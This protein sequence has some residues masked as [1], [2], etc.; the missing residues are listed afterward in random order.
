[1][2]ASERLKQARTAFELAVVALCLWAALYYTPMGALVRAVAS[3][4]TGSKT[5]A[6]PLL[7]YYNGG[8]SSGAS[9]R[10]ELAVTPTDPLT[11]DESLGWGA[12]GA[13]KQASGA[14]QQTVRA[15][16]AELGGNAARLESAPGGP[17]EL[18]AA[19]RKLRARGRRDT[20]AMLQLFAGDEAARFAE[21]RAEGEGRGTDLDDL[22]RQLPPGYEAGV[23]AASL[24]AMLGTGYA[25]AWPGPPDA[26]ITSPFGWRTHPVS[27]EQRFHKGIDLGIPT[28]TEVRAAGSGRVVRS[29]S[30]AYNGNIVV[31]S[32]GKDAR[33]LYLHNSERLVSVGAEVKQGEL[34]ARSGATGIATGPHLHYQLELGG[35]PWDPMLFAARKKEPAVVVKA[36]PPPPKGKKK[37]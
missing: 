3:F 24:A 28:G 10:V 30:D 18:G 29:S 16:V 6:R 19:I 13:Y 33:T 9:D 2:K 7:S 1:M 17:E 36:P 21:R 23:E 34:I 15:A 26:R 8:I 20:G 32:H 12:Y 4:A 11:W 35:E 37:K 27:G 31:I 14:T 25:L 22:A 5:S